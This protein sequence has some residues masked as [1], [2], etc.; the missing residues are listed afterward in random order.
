M[1]AEK[2]YFILYSLSGALSIFLHLYVLGALALSVSSSLIWGL[3]ILASLEFIAVGLSYNSQLEKTDAIN[4]LIFLKL[5]I[6]ILISLIVENYEIGIVLTSLLVSPIFLD[7]TISKYLFFIRVF[8]I[9]A[10][11]VLIL[12]SLENYIYFLLVGTLVCIRIYL[13]SY[14][15]HF[16]KINI[17]IKTILLRLVSYSLSFP[18]TMAASLFASIPFYY[19]AF[20]M[21]LFV[22]NQM[23]TY[24]LRFPISINILCIKLFCLILFLLV[25]GSFFYLNTFIAFLILN[26]L[27]YLLAAPL[28]SS[29]KKLDML[30]RDNYYLG[31]FV[32]F[33]ISIVNFYGISIDLLFIIEVLVLIFRLIQIRNFDNESYIK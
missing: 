9:S 24:L 4:A 29:Y 20:R 31:S 8:T 1:K 14:K 22:N 2:L 16:N 27:T 25:L 30:N 10:S 11:I 23:S 5:I 12:L 18:I 17:S 19:L 26:T 6:G 13:Y 32:I 21:Q 3:Y 15:F 28:Y 33:S 7:N